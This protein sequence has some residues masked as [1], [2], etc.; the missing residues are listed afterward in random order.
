VWGLMGIGRGVGCGVSVAGGSTLGRSFF[1]ALA[2]ASLSNNPYQHQCQSNNVIKRIHS[3]LLL[4]LLHITIGGVPD[5]VVVG[6]L[7]VVVDGGVDVVVGVAVV[8]G[9]VVVFG[10]VAQPP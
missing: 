7:G 3:P 8:V 1:V 9:V 4:H 10:V 2:I 6:L 5:G